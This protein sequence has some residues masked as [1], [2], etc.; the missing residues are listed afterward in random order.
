MSLVGT[1][2]RSIRLIEELGQGGM[3][4]VY[5]GR[6]EHLQRNVAVK[7]IRQDRRLDPAARARFLR[8]ARML[9]QLEHPNVCRLYEHVEQDGAEF[10]V[11]ELVQG[12]TLRDVIGERLPL[13]AKLSIASQIAAALAAA[14]AL[15]IVHRDLK[16]ENVV[17]MADGTVKVLDF[18]LARPIGGDTIGGGPAG[19]AVTGAGSQP[20]EA[21]ATLTGL[22]VMM[23]TPRYMSPE[24]ARGE[25]ATAA[26][27][28]YSFGLVL[29]ELLSGASPF[30]PD[31]P[32]GAMLQK[33]RW[34][35][36]LPPAGLGPDLT[37]LVNSLKS[38]L[39]RDRPD[40]AAVV[41][42]L[43]WIAEA[44]RRRVRRV[45]TAA[46][47]AALVAAAGISTFGYLRAERARTHAE[48]SEREARQARADTEAVNAFLRKMLSSADPRRMGIEIKVADVLDQ[49]V[50][51]AR[52]ELGGS[53][54][55]L[56]AVL[57]TI[58]SSYHALGA[59]AT[60]KP[61][62]EEAL[63]VRTAELGAE[64]PETLATEHRLGSLLS[65]QSAFDAAETMLAEVLER[66]TRV[67]GALHPDTLETCADLGVA[68]Q[69]ARKFKEA[70]EC[71]RRAYDGRRQALGDD[72]PATL[73]SM[74]QFGTIHVDF[75]RWSEAEP[76]LR[77]SLEKTRSLLGP[78]HPDT[79]AAVRSLG[80]FYSRQDKH[81]EA[82]VLFR[83]TWE[84]CTL[85]LGREHPVT[86]GA[87]KNLAGKLGS[88]KRFDEADALL[89]ETRT[90]AVKV[91]GP[92]HYE[93]LEI[94]RNQAA[95]AF[96]RG[97]YERAERII[98][99]RW[100]V[101]R[102]YLGDEHRVTLETWSVVA[103]IAWE[104]GRL[105]EAEATYRKIREV[106]A[107][108]LGA[109]HDATRNSTRYLVKLLRESGK[110]AEAD[111]LEATLPLD[112]RKPPPVTPMKKRA[113]G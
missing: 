9:S 41:G 104:S 80:V 84:Q 111:T 55:T 51:N 57:D 86:I 35:E 87:T 36:T 92:A 82:E 18:G 26:S 61:L 78:A 15:S 72:H 37:A 108:T 100:E 19:A 20:E 60:A 42:R 17:V 49:A 43:R 67:L 45:T 12:R 113:R 10:L 16:P 91:L 93:T 69:R 73:Q 110:T 31:L 47:A 50:A 11:L 64:S 3:G 7:A 63:A 65:D 71:Y 85:V 101:A 59:L 74:R 25:G 109:D 112:A 24:Q 77:Q 106:R 30:P 83:E 29:Q 14:H 68:L 5:L 103:L 95:N 53:P 56:A 32:P 21:D 4:E 66:R 22:G 52:A 33:A 76:L 58:G 98:T 38:F 89:A 79:I 97:D 28:M 8:E 90:A 48:A 6:D 70:E 107:R 34:A 62:I 44:P 46:V 39:Q 102:R 94:M 40:A 88:L 27:D 2:V 23:G 75:S 99:E 54:R 96:D 1:A 13:A 105:G 81:A